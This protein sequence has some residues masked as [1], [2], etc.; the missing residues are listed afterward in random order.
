M[1]LALCPDPGIHCLAALGL[2]TGTDRWAT[3]AGRH[4]FLS[5]NPHLQ[6]SS[7]LVLP[8]RGSYRASLVKGWATG[9]SRRALVG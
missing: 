5:R 9:K 6:A 4:L 3:Q 2:G 8:Q 7:P 1:T